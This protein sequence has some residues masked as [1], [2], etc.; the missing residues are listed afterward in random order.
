MSTVI[1]E[2]QSFILIC[3]SKLQVITDVLSQKIRWNVIWLFA[4][5]LTD[6]LRCLADA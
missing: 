3:D 4:V 6:L 2:Q 1:S 5:V